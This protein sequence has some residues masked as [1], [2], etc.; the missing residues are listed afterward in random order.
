[1]KVQIAALGD[2]ERSLAVRG[3]GVTLG[4][5]LETEGG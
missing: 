3:E 5:T 1:M 2:D 4:E